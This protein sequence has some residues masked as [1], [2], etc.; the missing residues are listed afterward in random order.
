MN[1]VNTDFLVFCFDN[2][3][4]FCGKH[5]RMDKI[6]NLKL[7]GHVIG[8]YIL[9]YERIMNIDLTS[10]HTIKIFSNYEFCITIKLKPTMAVNI[11]YHK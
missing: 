11:A 10:V 1:G 7:I 8:S 3:Q 9:K 5:K 6:I 2:W 4:H